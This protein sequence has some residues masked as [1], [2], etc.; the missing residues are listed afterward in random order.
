[1]MAEGA[2]ALGPCTWEN[3]DIL[4]QQKKNNPL[5]VGEKKSPVIKNQDVFS[6]WIWLCKAHYLPLLQQQKYLAMKNLLIR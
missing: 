3:A 2:S 1:M 4:Q 6:R 5:K